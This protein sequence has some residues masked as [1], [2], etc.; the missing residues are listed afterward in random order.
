MSGRRMQIETHG[1][2]FTDKI[3]IQLYFG[4]NVYSTVQ[5]KY[6]A[7]KKKLDELSPLRGRRPGPG[8][9][10]GAGAQANAAAAAARRAAGRLASGTEYRDPA[11]QELSER[12]SE[13]AERAGPDQSAGHPER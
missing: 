10:G 7:V 4:V 11:H 9:G 1:K 12:A 5:S 2:F 8:R 13:D 3:K 6:S